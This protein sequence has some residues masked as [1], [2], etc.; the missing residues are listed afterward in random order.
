MA[1]ATWEEIR[2]S[3]S[4]TI[5]K[6]LDMEKNRDREGIAN[7]IR[8]RFSERYIEPLRTKKAHGFCIMAV[9]CLMIEALESF[10]QG[11]PDTRGRSREAFRSFFE[12]CKRLGSLLGKF[13]EVADD[14]Y[15][16]RALRYFTSSGD[17]G[18]L[19]YSEGGPA[20]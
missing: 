2:L 13:S 4:V 7:F 10:W 15:R 12:R 5:R 3:S 9:C 20:V 19:A 14:F 17:N 11:W 1:R 18:R 8:E 16:G 6:Y